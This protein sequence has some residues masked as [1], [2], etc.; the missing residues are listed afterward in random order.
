MFLR[1][2]TASGESVRKWF[3]RFVKSRGLYNNINT[4]KTLAATAVT[5]N[6]IT[7]IKPDEAYYLA[8]RIN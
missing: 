7:A 1:G 6:L 2:T 8:D 3:H 4:W 5:R